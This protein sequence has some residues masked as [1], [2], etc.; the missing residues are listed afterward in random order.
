MQD[1]QK[2]YEILKDDVPGIGLYQTYAVYGAN[3]HLKW[4]PSPNEAM[5]VM[6]M[7]WQQ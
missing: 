4:Q 6:D 5:F 3:S 7:G 1:Y 2:A